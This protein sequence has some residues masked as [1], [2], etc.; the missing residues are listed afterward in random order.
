MPL[1]LEAIILTFNSTHDRTYFP[2]QKFNSG[3]KPARVAG[4]APVFFFFSREKS[5]PSSL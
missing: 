1:F 4:A 5:N 3:S 2:D